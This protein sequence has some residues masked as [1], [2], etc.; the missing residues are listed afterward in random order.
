MSWKERGLARF[1]SETSPRDQEH[2]VNI[3]GLLLF[4]LKGKGATKQVR[5]NDF[6]KKK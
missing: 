3:E 6:F 4:D 5:I 1:C 2:I